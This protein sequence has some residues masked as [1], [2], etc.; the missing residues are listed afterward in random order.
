MKSDQE[1]RIAESAAGACLI[2]SLVPYLGLVF[3]PAAVV[4]ALINGER[5]RLIVILAAVSGLVQVLL[6]W[7]L[8]VIPELG[9]GSL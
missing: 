9:R 6:W 4:F 5:R 7:L 3:V 2:Y 1:F 8:F